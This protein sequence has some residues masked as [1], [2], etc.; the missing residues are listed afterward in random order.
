MRSKLV[1][2]E[3]QNIG[4]LEDGGTVLRVAD[5]DDN[6]N[7]ATGGLRWCEC[8]MRRWALVGCRIPVSE[9]IFPESRSFTFQSNV[10]CT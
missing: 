8:A 7:D 5:D 9:E 10:S 3:R 2:E 6:D 4:L 1:M